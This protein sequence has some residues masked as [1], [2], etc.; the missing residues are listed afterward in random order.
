MQ[1]EDVVS[2]EVTKKAREEGH[3]VS[4]RSWTETE[5]AENSPWY[6]FYNTG[7]ETE[8]KQKYIHPGH[9]YIF[10]TQALMV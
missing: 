3:I 8:T 6:V 10:H 5:I 9:C 7:N 1:S 4:A 2:T